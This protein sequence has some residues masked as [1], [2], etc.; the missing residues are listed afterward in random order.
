VDEAADGD[1]R[2]TGVLDLGKAVPI[3]GGLILG[4][5]ERVK[6]EIARG[7]LALEGLEER[8]HAEELD[9]GDP[10]DDLLAAALHKKR[11]GGEHGSVLPEFVGMQTRKDMKLE[12][13]RR[14]KKTLLG[15][16]NCIGKKWDSRKITWVT[17]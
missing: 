6:G 12:L 14:R 9:E 4:E 8:N 3:K 16:Q 2:K 15:L 13:T 10:E 17:K 11:G 1:H 7:A 5:V